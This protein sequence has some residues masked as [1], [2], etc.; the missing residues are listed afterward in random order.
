MIVA[1]SD[2]TVMGIGNCTLGCGSMLGAG[3]GTIGCGNVVGSIASIFCRIFMACI[4]SSLT[5]DGDAGA[6]LLSNSDKYSTAW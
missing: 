4:F 5:I 1:L 3:D 6:G 2:V